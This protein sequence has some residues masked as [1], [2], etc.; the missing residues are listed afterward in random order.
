MKQQRQQ[1][2]PGQLLQALQ[3]EG[4]QGVLL[5]E[6]VARGTEVTL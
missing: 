3:Q 6:V 5:V 1:R 4:R 2:Q